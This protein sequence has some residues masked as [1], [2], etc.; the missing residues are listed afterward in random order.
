MSKQQAKPAI[1]IENAAKELCGMN[2]L[3]PPKW[4]MFAKTGAHKERPPQQGNWW[5]LRAASVLRTVS[6]KGPV[7]TQKLRTR[8]GGKYNAGHQ[9]EHHAKGSGSIIRHILQ[10]LE[11]AGLVE[12]KEKGVHKGRVITGKGA[13][14][15]HKAGRDGTVQAP[16]QKKATE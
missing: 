15:L 6:R 8:Y 11:K 7:G 9:T 4:A 10:G 12:Q 5:H 16:Q 13:K 14:I 3:E 1:I 2:E